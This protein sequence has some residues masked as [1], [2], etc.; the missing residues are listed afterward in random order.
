MHPKAHLRVSPPSE[1]RL[2]LDLRVQ[3]DAKPRA[4]IQTDILAI[5]ITAGRTTKVDDEARDVLGPAQPAQGVLLADDVF[6]AEVVDLRVRQAR[7]E[8]SRC[9][10]VRR[11]VLRRQLHRE[12]AS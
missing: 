4:A 8:E 10:H 9:D 6:A 5:D 11:D 2:P 12:V 3:A 1:L 7:G